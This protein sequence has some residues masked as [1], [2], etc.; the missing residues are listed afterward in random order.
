MNNTIKQ[1]VLGAP[2][3]AAALSLA[4]LAIACR[5][6]NDHAHP[7]DS[8]HGH[9]HG[10]EPAAEH[11]HEPAANQVTIWS[12]R[13]EIF[14][15][16][17]APAAGQPT[18][19]ITHVS[20][21]L[22]GEPRRTGQLTF[23]LSEGTEKLEQTQYAPDRAGIYIPTLTF[24]RAGEWN[25]QVVVPGETN[26]VIDLGTIEVHPDQAAAAK[27]TFPEAPE[28]ISFL[29][30][31]QWRILSKTRPVERAKLTQRVPLPATLIP[32]P[33][34]KASVHSPVIGRVVE[35]VARLGAETKAGDLLAWVEPGFT[36]FTTKL[37]E[38]EAEGIRAKAN[39]EQARLVFER[40]K[41]LHE[42][43]AKSNREL[44]ETELA[45]RAAQG[46][47]DAALALQKV[48][49]GTGAQMTDGSVRLGLKAPI[50]GILDK[51]MVGVGDRV[52]PE[53]PLFTIV[54]PAR[55]YLQAQ[56]PAQRLAEV[57]TE[58]GTHFQIGS[59]RSQPALT[60][61]QF[62]AIGRELDPLTRTIPITYEFSNQDRPLPIGTL[63]TLFLAT[64]SGTNS[65]A[66]PPSAIVEDEGVP[67]VFVQ[68][69]GE[70]FD[71]RDVDIGIRDGHLTEIRSG[72]AEGER[73]VVDGA[74]PLL[75]STKSGA[76][77]A[78]GH[79]H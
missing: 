76:I 58:L 45:L 1:F 63:G 16:H 74:Y 34:S 48:Y 14:A 32:A 36:E 54:N 10:P 44:Q 6:S 49:Q 26:A 25:L 15:E 19:F 21:I 68:L 47:Y 28:G 12:G 24:P 27:A 8:D 50:E 52:T 77:P 41:K 23:V 17:T 62:V 60:N 64:G 53:Q 56:V 65:L 35:Q 29:K 67:V 57:N 39:L 78:H 72:L 46:A 33:G 7:H 4:L 3:W 30:E 20:D 22:T 9:E 79:T 51:V 31:Q 37:V 73:V 18:R 75:L 43:Q 13:Y 61:L 55:V 40:T 71:K 38:A 5:K 66:V 2:G 69:S 70:T 11:E 59:D 42:Q